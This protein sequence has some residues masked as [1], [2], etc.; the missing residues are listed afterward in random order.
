MAK[1]K[2][3]QTGSGA[4]RQ[5]GK[6]GGDTSGGSGAG[7]AKQT[8]AKGKP[9]GGAAG[10][11]RGGG[12]TAQGKGAPFGGKKAKPFSKGKGKKK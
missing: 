4:A 3:G 10:G 9:T 7:S 12:K 6:G 1:G 8:P 2:S 5:A 11:V